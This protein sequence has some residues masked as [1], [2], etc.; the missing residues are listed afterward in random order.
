[1]G[2]KWEE[3]AE[4]KTL[5]KT[6]ASLESKGFKVYVAE[7]GKGAFKKVFEIIPE[8]AEVMDNTST[9][10]DTL[11]IS[12][13]IQ[14]SGKYQSVRKKVMSSNQKDMRDAMRKMVSMSDYAIGSA[15]AV[16]ENGEIVIASNSG[17]Q[18]PT[19]A[20]NANKVIWV[21]GTQKIVKNIDEAL[22]RIEKYSLPLEDAR[23]QKAYG[24]H[25]GINKILIVKGEGMPGRI[26][27]IF[28]KEKLG[29]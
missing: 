18:L 15:N 26:Q 11:G 9:T 23:A 10:L 13:E 28:V 22:E 27:I 17:S 25:S 4:D 29:F 7:D 14:E 3:L 5:A 21:V 12:K 2:K 6:I 19:Y 1:M 20:F 24:M 8:G 16:T